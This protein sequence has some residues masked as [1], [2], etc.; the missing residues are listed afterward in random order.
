V[1]RESYPEKYKNGRK[2]YMLKP[3][4]YNSI[5]SAEA[6]K[7]LKCPTNSGMQMTKGSSQVT[8]LRAFSCF[9]QLP[10]TLL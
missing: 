9:S 1:G 3:K 2:S 4:A 6:S 8:K 7:V 5:F 10:Q